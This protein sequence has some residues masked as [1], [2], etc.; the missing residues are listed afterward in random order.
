MLIS[1]L[2]TRGLDPLFGPF[3]DVKQCFDPPYLKNY[4]FHDRYYIFGMLAAMVSS[5]CR[6]LV[7]VG[8][9]YLS[10][11]KSTNYAT[12]ISLYGGIG[13]ISAH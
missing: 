12:L 6:G 5:V 10:G 13:G 1:W 8:V 3:F 11:N 7:V 4:V 9:G 2:S